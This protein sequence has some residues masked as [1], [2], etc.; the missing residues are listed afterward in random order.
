MREGGRAASDLSTEQRSVEQ[1]TSLWRS[2]PNSRLSRYLNPTL[3]WAPFFLFLPSISFIRL[4]AR[5]R[6]HSI[7]SIGLARLVISTTAYLVW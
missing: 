5:I 1:P 4:L 6:S 3:P 2:N 7:G